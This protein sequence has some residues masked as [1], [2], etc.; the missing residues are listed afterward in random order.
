MNPDQLASLEVASLE[1]SRSGPTLF[2]KEGKAF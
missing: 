1:A 2:S